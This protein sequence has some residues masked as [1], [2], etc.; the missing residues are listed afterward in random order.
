MRASYVEELIR[1]KILS[2]VDRYFQIRASLRDG[3]KV[4]S[5]LFLI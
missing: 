5:L 4:E 3:D 2:D 1:V